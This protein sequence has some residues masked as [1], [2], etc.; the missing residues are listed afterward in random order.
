M[1]NDDG[2]EFNITSCS[3]T[4]HYLL[5]MVVDEMKKHIGS[6]FLTYLID[7]PSGLKSF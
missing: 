1:S 2:S 3:I 5:I 7:C 4:V 6:C